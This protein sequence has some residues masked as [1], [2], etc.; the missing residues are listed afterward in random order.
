MKDPLDFIEDINR[1]L[2]R[3]KDADFFFSYYEYEP[4]SV[5]DRRHIFKVPSHE[6][7]RFT[8]EDF[9]EKAPAGYEVAF[10]SSVRIDGKVFHIPVFDFM[11]GV[12]KLSMAMS[13]S[14]KML[15]KSVWQGLIFFDSG[16]SMHGYARTL[17][18]AQAF[19]K[20]LGR[21][22]L[23]NFPGEEQIIDSRWIGHRLIAGYG[24]LRI[25][26]RTKHYLKCPSYVARA[27]DL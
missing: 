14:K 18:G 23:M 22:L 26:Q 2:I 25:S 1:S 7:N 3:G 8:L 17:V 12:D 6:L 21:A 20:I 10:H 19:R 11:C 9:I 4:Q 24:T 16:R 27:A 5:L 15:P 13:V